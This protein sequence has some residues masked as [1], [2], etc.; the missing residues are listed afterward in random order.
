V[1]THDGIRNRCDEPVAGLDLRRADRESARREREGAVVLG[2]GLVGV[3][4]DPKTRATWTSPD[5]RLPRCCEDA[6]PATRTPEEVADRDARP[7]AHA[8][9]D[10]EPTVAAVL[11]GK[12]FARRRHER[13]DD[14]RASGDEVAVDGGAVDAVRLV[15]D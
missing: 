6:Q 15:L 12:Q 8:K 11:A 3:G 14:D 5:A 7:R 9:R 4:I 1:G 10:P 13:A 2:R